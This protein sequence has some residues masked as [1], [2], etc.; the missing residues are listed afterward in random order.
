MVKNNLGN[1]DMQDQ[2]EPTLTVRGVNVFKGLLSKAEQSAMVDDLR[3]VAQVAPFFTPKT[4]SGQSM[5]VKMTSAGRF[6]WVS[7]ANGYRY[8]QQHPS[9][10]AW[11]EIPQSVL[12][13]WNAVSR[14]ERSPESCL[15]NY[16]SSTAKMGLHQDRDEKDFSAPV[17]SI[18]L[19]DSALF[20]IGNET[21]GGSTESIW[22]ESGDVC[23]LG[24][25]SRLLFHGIDRVKPNTS[26]LLTNGGRINV[27]LR[28]VT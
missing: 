13:V 5:S 18:S 7:D 3:V 1:K 10:V 23:V 20:R 6:G 2:P 26:T 11:P 28:V 8:E 14:S 24:G 16:Y 19:G 25:P 15:I 9:G 21:R 22:L 17:V 27:T 12:A 4:A